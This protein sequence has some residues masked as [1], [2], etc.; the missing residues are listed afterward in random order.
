MSNV[1]SLESYRSKQ[2]L[3]QIRVEYIDCDERI[4]MTKKG[5]RNTFICEGDILWVKKSSC[6]DHYDQEHPR[7]LKYEVPVIDLVELDSGREFCL[8]ISQLNYLVEGQ[9]FK[10][11]ND[12]PYEF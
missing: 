3:V 2:D 9:C 10:A 11:R 8:S 5:Q 4:Y 6:K 1:V 7:R 12:Y